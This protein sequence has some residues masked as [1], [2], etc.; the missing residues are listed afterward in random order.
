[1]IA[2]DLEPD[3]RA[4]LR[5]LANE[6]STS[7]ELLAPDRRTHFV[8]RMGAPFA[9]S[10]APRM[11]QVGGVAQSPDCHHLAWNPP[12]MLRMCPVTKLASSDSRKE[13][14]FAISSGRPRRF[15]GCIALMLASL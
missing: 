3:D 4:L 7:D 15:M 11:R 14:P 13:M 5:E 10:G 6:G 1:V 9:P 8:P 12:S 2:I